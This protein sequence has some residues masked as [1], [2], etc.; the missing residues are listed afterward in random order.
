MCS[1][2]AFWI[3]GV[4]ALALSGQAR[5]DTEDIIIRCLVVEAEFDGAVYFSNNFTVPHEKPTFHGI[6]EGVHIE[7]QFYGEAF[8]RYVRSRYATSAST[9]LYSHG[10]RVYLPGTGSQTYWHPHRVR[11]HVYGGAKI[12]TMV[13]WTPDAALV[14]EAARHRQRHHDLIVKQK[15]AGTGGYFICRATSTVKEFYE[16]AVTLSEIIPGPPF[17]LGADLYA[18]DGA[19]EAFL[20]KRWQAA[21]TA[22]L[23][24]DTRFGCEYWA[25]TPDE[26]TRT[27][28]DLTEYFGGSRG[29]RSVGGG[30]DRDLVQ[31]SVS[32]TAWK[33]DDDAYREYGA[34]VPPSPLAASS[35]SIKV[36]SKP[37]DDRAAK[38]RAQRDAAAAATA[39]RERAAREAARLEEFQRTAVVVAQKA[40]K[41]R[42]QARN[43]AKDCMSRETRGSLLEYGKTKADA[44]RKVKRWGA[45]MCGGT[46]ATLS[47]HRC[48][49]KVDWGWC[50]A[51]YVCPSRPTACTK[52]ATKQ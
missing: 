35:G 18:Y 20:T 42:E 7:L 16:Y 28:R 34:S 22:R 21:M 52:G 48:D 38:E 47:N 10:C 51:E 1:R 15:G 24:K 9:S 46:P 5:A 13:S 19:F 3:A 45:R 4:V 2:S 49:P 30:T 36:E 44:E 12:Q 25:D 31:Y 6:E 43:P 40:R 8:A 26:I 14:A 50:S 33:L 29:A 39:A 37:A 17:A 27:K 41:A 11:G 23:P 32:D